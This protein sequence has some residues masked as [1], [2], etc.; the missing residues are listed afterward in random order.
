MIGLKNIFFFDQ[1]KISKIVIL[2]FAIMCCITRLMV[3][4]ASMHAH[5]LHIAFRR[6]CRPCDLKLAYL[7]LA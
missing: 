4:M 5:Y 2:V 6:V 1:L 3:T 7:G